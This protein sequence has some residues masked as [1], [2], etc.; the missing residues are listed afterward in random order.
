MHDLYECS[1]LQTIINSARWCRNHI[2]KTWDDR[3]EVFKTNS[4]AVIITQSN[5]FILHLRESLLIA[6]CDKMINTKAKTKT[7]AND[8]QRE[9]K[10][11]LIS[12][13][14]VGWKVCELFTAACLTCAWKGCDR[15]IV[16]LK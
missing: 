9:R 13:K 16:E 1:S 5:T 6:Y 15:D 7:K 3:A 8:D 11:L 14:D 4:S 10:N 2:K 12:L